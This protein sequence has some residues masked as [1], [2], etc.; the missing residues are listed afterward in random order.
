[1]QVIVISGSRN[2]NGQTAA[3]GDAFLAG[4]AEAGGTG[5]QV[6]LPQMNIE[7]CR[8]CE[9][10]GWGLCNSQGR[11]VI[12]D[13]FPALV[14][15]LRAADGLAFATPVYYSDLSESLRA[16]LDRLRRI[17]THE[18][19]NQGI[20][21]KPAMGICV[22]GGGGGGAPK[23]TVTLEWTLATCGLDVV[24]MVPARRQNLQMKLQVLK[25]VGKWF[26]GA[27]ERT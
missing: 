14:D 12:E 27:G 9:D 22:A 18:R 16:F 7:R 26:A 2:P 13:D 10:H 25:T 15:R 21:G 8:Q 20:A 3:A 11:C 5:Q 23:C 24:D 6:F 17:C 19:G 4:I 1:M